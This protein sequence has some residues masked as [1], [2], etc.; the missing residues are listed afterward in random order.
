MVDQHMKDS[1]IQIGKKRSSKEVFLPDE[2]KQRFSSKDDLLFYFNHQLYV[3]SHSV[4]RFL[5]GNTSLRPQ[6]TLTGIS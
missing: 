3:T 1:A 6:V 4:N 5:I 2:L